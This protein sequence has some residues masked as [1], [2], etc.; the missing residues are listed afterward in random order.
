MGIPR[1]LA[2]ALGVL[3]WP[4]AMHA[5]AT[6]ADSVPNVRIQSFS[7]IVPDYDEA[8]RWYEDR[9]GFATITSISLRLVAF[10]L[11]G[12]LLE[13][14]VW[15]TAIGVVPSCLL[16]IWVARKI[17]LRIPRDALMRAV[18]LLLLASGASLIWRALA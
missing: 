16:G 3:L 4:A 15:L 5:Q 17:F 1:H 13:K 18:A 7:V 10:A 9:L 6:P 2:A 8:K 12:L 11:T 14:A